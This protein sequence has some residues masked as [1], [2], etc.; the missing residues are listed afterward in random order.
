MSACLVSQWYCAPCAALTKYI[1]RQTSDKGRS[2]FV[3]ELTYMTLTLQ[4]IPNYQVL[5]FLPALIGFFHMLEACLIEPT[6]QVLGY[7]DVY[8]YI[9]PP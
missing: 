6:I 1:Y 3:I 7:G 2:N 5:N 9:Y 4:L 8:I